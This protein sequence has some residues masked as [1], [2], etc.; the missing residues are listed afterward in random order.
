MTTGGRSSP[1][2]HALV[3]IMSWA[4]TSAHQRRQLIASADSFAERPCACANNGR[5]IARPIR[6]N[7]CDAPQERAPA[8]FDAAPAVS[9]SA[10]TAARIRS[11]HFAR[12]SADG[13]ARKPQR[14]TWR[15]G[16]GRAPP[17]RARTPWAGASICRPR[18][19]RGRPHSVLRSAIAASPSR[20][21]TTRTTHCS[22]CRACARTR[23]RCA[24]A[25]ARAG[26]GGA[27]D[28]RSTL[29]KSSTYR[30]NATRSNFRQ[31]RVTNAPTRSQLCTLLTGETRGRR[32]GAQAAPRARLRRREGPCAAR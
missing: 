10:A 6:R 19:T 26:A 21:R 25:V 14:S 22:A 5:S 13:R 20:A 28:A 3:S 18:I 27:S 31:M 1:P 7:W 2:A 9:S 8:S 16:S 12:L 30:N 29:N 17:P 32:D 4:R 15:R 24:A 23:R 11:S